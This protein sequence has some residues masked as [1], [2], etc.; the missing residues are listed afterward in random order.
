[1]AE[2]RKI[3]IE[4]G[5]ADEP[6]STPHFDTEA[7]LTA[8]PV[9]PL[10]E[11]DVHQL[12]YGAH[13][14]RAAARPFWKRPAMLA[15][16]VLVA[17]GIGVGAGLGI[18]LYRNRQTA[19][20]P[21]AAAPSSTAEDVDAGQTVEHLP[22]PPQPT[23][24]ERA[25][26]P[27]DEREAPPVEPKREDEPKVEERERTAITA[28]NERKDDDDE[29][30]RPAAAGKPATVARAKKPI[31]VDEYIVE[32]GRGEGRAEEDQR[33]EERRAERRERRRRRRES[34]MDIPRDMDRAG[35]E[36][37]RIREIFEGRQ[38]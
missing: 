29:A 25:A 9:V 7:T 31:K 12:P 21:V 16:I 18:G 35:K 5:A 32:D 3:I 11:Q 23:P 10:N 37:N 13:S 4:T 30:I 19:P 20:T 36:V 17:V 26:V 1:M 24:Q 6:L 22:A 34:E 27:T 38:P 14:G 28:R 2:R 15:L 33:R 8:R